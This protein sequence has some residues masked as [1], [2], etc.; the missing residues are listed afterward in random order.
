MRR[1]FLLLLLLA[2]ALGCPA[3]ARAAPEVDA[4]AQC[5]IQATT[6]ADRK[7]AVRWTFATMALDPD[8][9]SMASVTPAERDA[10]N[11][12]AGAL[13]TDLLTRSCRQSVQ[14][15]LLSGGPQGIAT[16]FEAWGRWAVM[17]LATQ[18]Q[19]AAGMAGL[20]QYIDLGKLM[21]MLPLSGAS[22]PGVGN[23]RAVAPGASPR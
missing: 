20:L 6:P 9:A 18:P 11:R 17:G 7:V 10:I 21:S 19:V 5:L 15:A 14:Q 8:V 12:R 22:H 4:L 23:P 2:P 13:V 3:M 16:A 1:G